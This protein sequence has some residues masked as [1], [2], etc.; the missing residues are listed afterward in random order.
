[1]A[2]LY[3]IVET[4]KMSAEYDGSKIF[5][6]YRANGALENGRLIAVDDSTG[7]ASY[8]VTASTKVYL[9]ASVEVMADTVNGLT[10]FRKDD[11]QLV[12]LLNM[13]NGDEFATTAF[14]AGAVKG[15]TVILETATGNLVKAGTAPT[16]TENFIGEVL[17]V[18]TLGYDRIPALSVR[19]I[20][21]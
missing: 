7:K 18:V 6:T 12:R 15:D 5:N 8:A 19:V 16:G 10:K 9:H 1:M 3:D 11:G 20:K 14:V 21:A 4:S 17:D 13:Q 2:K